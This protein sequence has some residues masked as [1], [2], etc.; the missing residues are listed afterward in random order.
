Y[1]EEKKK[2]KTIEKN[3]EVMK[4][5]ILFALKEEGKEVKEEELEEA[6][7]KY[8][9][10]KGRVNP[11]YF[12]VW[13]KVSIMKSLLDQN[14]AEKIDA[15]EVYRMRDYVKDFIRDLSRR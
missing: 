8:L 11:H 2:E 6:L 13:R 9:I 3:Y 10:D 14:K 15:K 4:K 12:D 7:K 5:A 1:L